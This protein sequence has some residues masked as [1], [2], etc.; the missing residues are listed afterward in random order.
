MKI[1][2]FFFF[3][4]FSKEEYE[5]PMNNRRLSRGRPP[6]EYNSR[7]EWDINDFDVPSVN[8]FIL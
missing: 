3:V 2:Q 8:N 5:A 6:A 1:I 7:D 4:Y